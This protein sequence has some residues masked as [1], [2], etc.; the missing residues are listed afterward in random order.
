MADIFVSYA[1]EDR[2]RVEPFIELL[3]KQG[4]SIWWDKEVVPGHSFGNVID[5][6]ID[7]AGCVIVFWSR[8]SVESNWVQVEANEGLERGVLIPVLLD[9]VRVPLIFRQIETVPLLGWP[10]KDEPDQLRRIM[11][12]VANILATGPDEFVLEKVPASSGL[13]KRV[14]FTA[15]ALIAIGSTAAFILLRETPRNEDV[16]AVVEKATQP[17]ASIAVMPFTDLEVDISP[18]L[19]VVLG[20]AESL[21]VS[22][23]QHVAAHLAN[24]GTVKLD[25]RYTIQGTMKNGSLTV[26][27]FDR[28]DR[29]TVWQDTIPTNNANL[30]GVVQSIATGV[31]DAFN[32]PTVRVD[33]VPHVAY[34]NYL[35]ARAQLRAD[36]GPEG[37]NTA[38][39]L[40]QESIETA[41]R[42]AEAF[43]G[44]CEVYTTRYL[45]TG[46]AADFE[47]AEKRCF[48]AATLSDGNP[49]VDFALGRLYR[50]A[51]QYDSAM[52]RFEAA[53]ARTPFSTDVLR[54]MAVVKSEQNLYDEAVALMQ[55][56]IELE[57]SYWKNHD[58]LAALYFNT[59]RY[60][61]AAN[62]YEK[63]AA[64][65]AD[66]TRVL[67]DLGS[68]YFMA[69][70]FDQ[71]IDAWN[72]SMASQPTRY[73]LS[74]LGSAYFF[75][76]EYEKALTTYERAAELSLHDPRVWANT[77]EA[78]MHAGKDATSYFQKAVDAATEQFRINPDNAEVLSLLASSHAALGNR[79]QAESFIDRALGAAADDVYV[80]YDIAVAYAHLGKLKQRDEMISSMIALGYSETLIDRDA[81]LTRRSP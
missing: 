61:L 12:T 73:S 62:E 28:Q 46:D 2:H 27:M 44:L 9:D 71:A 40:L 49:R 18:E 10:G 60:E 25:A 65:G 20:K 58:D 54:E 19:A 7:Q 57:P 48:R 43:A 59:G 24:P 22:S 77:G 63:M 50:I 55:A 75:N 1:R 13:S 70:K 66:L 45:E 23:P 31:L 42:F 30:S 47:N 32:K 52:D 41:P 21:F 3:E 6:Q 8:H 68:A 11:D 76:G 14:L 69:E 37:I 38:E 17:T 26:T 51:G 15:L 78:A 53:L 29:E 36:R 56:A 80:L 74:N 72:E 39:S 4:W 64:L 79:E 34:L 81:N 67:N 33:D 35:K 16:P 5:K